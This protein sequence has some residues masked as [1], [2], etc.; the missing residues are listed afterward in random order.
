MFKKNMG[1]LSDKK[2]ACLTLPETC[3]RGAGASFVRGGKRAMNKSLAEQGFLCTERHRR[4]RE[5]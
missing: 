2:T 3:F 5:A 1:A 4:K